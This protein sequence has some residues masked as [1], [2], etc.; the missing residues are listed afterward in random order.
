MEK[1]SNHQEAEWMNK[2][3]YNQVTEKLNYEEH[4]L[5]ILR[6]ENK[7]QLPL[8][9]QKIISYFDEINIKC[10]YYKNNYFAINSKHDFVRDFLDKGGFRNIYIKQVKEEKKQG[11]IDLLNLKK[12]KSETR[13]SQLKLKT[14]WIFFILAALGFVLS[15]FS[16]IMQFFFKS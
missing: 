7:S 3:L 2:I 13:L 15:V 4:A 9:I 11:E 16:L 14:F 12:L 1:I 6:K 5:E 10:Y 8:L